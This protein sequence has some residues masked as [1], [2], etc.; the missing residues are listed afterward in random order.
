MTLLMH[1]QR[2]F[3]H[4]AVMRW[5][6]RRAFSHAVCQ[7]IENA[8]ATSE[9]GHRAEIR[10]V[11][12]GALDWP[13][14]WRNLDARERAVSLFSD[15]HIWDTEHNTGILVYVLFAEKKLEIV[16]DRGISARVD[17]QEWES[18]CANMTKAFQVGQFK[19]GS[20]EGLK[21][22]TALLQRHFPQESSLAIEELSNQVVIL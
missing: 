20:I 12:E 8:I 2:F 9:L 15:L 7:S 21:R 5:Q 4:A 22:I 3:K 11:V 6:V 1:T 16:A 14:L 19:E 18:I 13:Q 10:F 17:Q